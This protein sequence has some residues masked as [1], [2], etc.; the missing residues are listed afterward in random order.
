M[1]DQPQP[2]GIFV[3]CVSDEFEKDGA[4][5]PGLRM[6]LRGYLARTR[7]NV[8]VQEDFPQTN[9]DTVKKLADEI[10]PLA[11]VIHL[12][13]EKPGA[14]ANPAAVA[15][16][17]KDA[18]DFLA[19]HPELRAALGDFSGISYTQWE[20]FIALHHDIPLLVY[21]IDKASAQQTHLDRL[22]L[23]RRYATL[24]KNDTDLFGQLIGDL[25]E[26]LPVVPKLI[27]KIAG[28][29]LEKHAPRVLFGREEE[30]AA[31]DAAWATGDAEHLH[32]G[33][34]GRSGQDLARVPLGADALRG[35][36]AQV[37]WRRALLRLE[38][39][40][41]GDRR[42]PADLRRPVYRQGARVLRRPRSDRGRP[43]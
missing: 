35:E 12:V 10:R 21:A 4:P 13:G 14:I 38:L 9:V 25:N 28:T 36:R 8:R 23:A 15:E 3:S 37:A 26:I 7:T 16:Y 20:A 19:N 6:Q 43:A 41:P 42:K 22:K 17:L 5:F 39:L 1:S 27:R 32:P 33:G 2:N 11:V 34:L 40:Q 29:Q 24:I 31:L 30:L 18:P